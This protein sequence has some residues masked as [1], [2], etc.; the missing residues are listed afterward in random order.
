MADTVILTLTGR[1]R[2]EKGEETV[3]RLTEKAEFYAKAG[4]LYLLYQEPLEENGSSVKCCIKLK[5]SVLEITKSGALRTRM[6]FE[7]G[8]E[9]LTEYATPYGSLRIGVRTVKTEVLR[10]GDRLD[11]RMEYSLTSQGEP[12]SHCVMEI[13]AQPLPKS[14]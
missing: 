5:G 1:Q 10:R 13:T 7:E 3:T 6:V 2:S 14:I 11:I 9:Y 4:S 12:F 8:K